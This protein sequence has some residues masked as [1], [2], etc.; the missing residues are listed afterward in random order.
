MKSIEDL[1]KKIWYRAIKVV[2]V[3]VF[4]LGVLFFSIELFNKYNP[5]INLER[6]YIKCFDGSKKPL[7]S[8]RIG[9]YLDIGTTRNPDKNVMEYVKKNNHELVEICSSEISGL[10]RVEI[11]VHERKWADMIIELFIMYLLTFV[12]FEILRRIFYY[13]VLGIWKGP[14]KK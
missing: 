9:K 3:S 1:N 11:F 12:A 10:D 7:K 2:Y 14:F 6:S 4:I 13:I 5:T 8:L